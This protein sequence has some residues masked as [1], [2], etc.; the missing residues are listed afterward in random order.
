MY[1]SWTTY[2]YIDGEFVFVSV[3]RYDRDIEN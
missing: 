3:E 2:S 1:Q